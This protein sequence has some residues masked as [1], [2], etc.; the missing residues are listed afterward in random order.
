[1]WL[2]KQTHKQEVASGQLENRNKIWSK[3]QVKYADILKS[4]FA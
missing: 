4:E 3:L 2:V 1:M